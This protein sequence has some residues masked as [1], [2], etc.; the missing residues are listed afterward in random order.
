MIFNCKNNFHLNYKQHHSN[1]GGRTP[2]PP[3][4][5][6]RGKQRHQKE[7]EKAA[8]PHQGRRENGSTA[9]EE[10]KAAPLKGTTHHHAK[11]GRET[12]APLQRRRGGKAPPPTKRREVSPTKGS[13]VRPP[14]GRCCFP[15]TLWSG[16]ALLL[17]FLGGGTFFPLPFCVHASLHPLS[18]WVVLLSSSFGWC[19]FSTLPFMGGVFS[20]ASLWCSLLSSSVWVVVFPSLPL[21]FMYNVRPRRQFTVD[22]NLK[23]GT[24]NQCHPKGGGERQPRP[25]WE[26]ITP[27]KMLLSSLGWCCFS[28]PCG[29]L[30][31][32]SFWWCFFYP[33]PIVGGAVSLPS[34][35]L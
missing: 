14:W 16:A 12:A 5:R 4:K 34:S 29:V 25:R 23:E 3:E 9:M 15:L 35:L 2:A 17:L 33:S 7:E 28:P 32:S 8:P 19:C 6:R 18:F 11:E 22:T 10:V 27:P 21:P 31:S 1:R 20:P 30:L 24:W 13:C 26:L